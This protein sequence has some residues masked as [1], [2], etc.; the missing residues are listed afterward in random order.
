M[1]LPLL[2]YTN[3]T[4]SLFYF[5]MD[6][7]KIDQTFH[8]SVIIQNTMLGYATSLNRATLMEF[9]CRICRLD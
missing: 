1:G 7:K 9:I 3:C 2:Y 6:L 5:P 4:Y 8:Y